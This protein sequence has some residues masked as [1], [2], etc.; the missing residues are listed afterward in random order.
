VRSWTVT[1]ID[2][3]T[4]DLSPGEALTALHAS[5]DARS[6]PENVAVLMLRALAGRLS[7]GERMKRDVRRARPSGGAGGV[8]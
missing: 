7:L 1:I 2:M 6:R 4:A 8:R 5:L 3:S